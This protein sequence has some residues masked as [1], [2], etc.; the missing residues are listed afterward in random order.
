MIEYVERHWIFGLGFFAQI[1]FGLRVLV[2][3]WMAEKK[4]HVVSPSLFW[5]LSLTGAGLFLVYGI[6]RHDFVIILGQLAAYFIYIRNL[7]LKKD[8]S[9]FSLSVQM[10][11]LAFP[12]IA[13]VWT[14]IHDN[15][16]TLTYTWSVVLW[17]GI[18]GQMLLNFRFLYQLYYS[19]QRKES[20]LPTGFW[21][22]SLTGSIFVITYSVYRE[23]PVLLLAQSL[24]LVPYIRN[25]ILSKI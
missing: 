10:F 23:D 12:V 15:I 4:G 25:I 9:K 20:L 1:M 17:I 16:K 7:Q 8:W 24:A 14:L 2:Q 21:W 3:W 11:L 22:I 19:E 6:L 18:I 5:K 13:V